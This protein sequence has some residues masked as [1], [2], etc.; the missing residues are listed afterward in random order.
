MARNE[1]P[2]P[3]RANV[4]VTG[5]VIFL[6]SETMFFAALFATYFD[7]KSTNLIW[8]SPI[9]KFDEVSMAIGTFF[10]WAG[11]ATMFP[12]LRAL[13]KR[14]TAAARAWLYTSIIAGIG[15]LGIELH[16]WVRDT[17]RLYSDAYGSIEYFMT[18]V[19]FLHVLVGVI[20]LTALY[21]GLR[22]PTFTADEYAGAEAVS[23]YWH[24]V[25]IV[26]IGIYTT[27]FWIK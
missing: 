3:I 19:H 9:A 20:L 17:E 5:T 8:P 15:F 13:R 11:S 2:L 16:S 10:L 18:G 1:R 23:Y 4:L 14:N 26:W 24:F 6:A 27:V 25:F 12:F 7:L 22:S 21:F